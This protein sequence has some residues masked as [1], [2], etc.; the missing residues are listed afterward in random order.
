MGTSLW[1]HEHTGSLH[2][3]EGTHTHT[4]TAHTHKSE[5]IPTAS[6]LQSADMTNKMHR[7]PPQTTFSSIEKSCAHINRNST[8]YWRTNTDGPNG[9]QTQGDEVRSNPRMG[10]KN[11]SVHVRHVK[12]DTSWHLMPGK[13]ITL[14]LYASKYWHFSI[15]LI[16]TIKFSSQT[17]T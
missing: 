17:L 2:R 1:H 4:G 11:T 9:K 3:Y 5:I 8:R 12:E 15:L 6:P 7:R 13:K 16:C 14:L 10:T